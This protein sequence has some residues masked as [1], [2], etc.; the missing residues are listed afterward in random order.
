[1]MKIRV[2]SRTRDNEDCKLRDTNVEKW[3]K[4]F[5]PSD[6]QCQSSRCDKIV[7][8]DQGFHPVSRNHAGNVS[9]CVNGTKQPGSTE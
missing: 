2:L 1:M 9:L 6:V 7:S 5:R 8:S 4:Q 3:F